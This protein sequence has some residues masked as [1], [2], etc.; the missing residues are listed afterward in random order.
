MKASASERLITN[1]I[2]SIIKPAFAPFV[3]QFEKN[4]RFSDLL[5]DGVKFRNFLT[6]RYA[7]DVTFQQANSSSGNNQEEK[8]YYSGKH[9]LY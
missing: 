8:E 1:F 4:M 5:T 9:K 2:D 6:P 3:T 7:T